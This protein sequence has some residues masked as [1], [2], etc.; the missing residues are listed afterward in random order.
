METLFL[1]YHESFEPDIAGIIERHMVV[2][3][4]TRI[5]NVIGARMAEREQETG[6]PA[7]RRNRIIM[8]VAESA[9]INRILSDLKALR[10]RKGHGLRAFVVEAETVI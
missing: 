4:F 3:R 6:S 1:I 7:E 2:A 9:T 5:D 10:E 8:L